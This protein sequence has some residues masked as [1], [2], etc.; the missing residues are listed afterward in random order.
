MICEPGK[1]CICEK[2]I[3]NTCESCG[4]K[5]FS[6]EHTRVDVK[7]SNGS[8]M[9]IGVC[10]KCAEDKLVENDEVKRG[11]TEAHWKFWEQMGGQPDKEVTIV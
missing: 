1:C 2:D 11:I 3:A 5:K 6:D 9:P 7:W 4:A 8:V 10:K